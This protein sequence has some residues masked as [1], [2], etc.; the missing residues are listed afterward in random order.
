MKIQAGQVAVI[1]GAG[2]GIGRQLAIQLAQR[3]VNLALVDIN[4]SALEATKESLSSYSISITLHALNIGDC[5]AMETLAGDVIAEHGG[6]NILIN[7][8]GI[9]IQKSFETHSIADWQR[10]MDVNWWGVIYACKFF[11]P[12]LKVAG[13]SNTAHIVNL[14]SMAGFLG[15]PNQASYCSTK[16]A[17]RMLS[18]SLW[19]ELYDDNIGVTSVHPGCVKTD[20]IRATLAESDNVEIAERHYQMAQRIGVSADYAAERMIRAIEKNSLRIRI[21]KDAVVLD[22]LKR[23]LPKGI[24][25]PMIK[26]FRDSAA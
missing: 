2:G 7:N 4:Q 8:A 14:S 25:K 1:T 22:L 23:L 18:E 6:V 11:L 10:V 3:G 24:L 13:R 9:T 15:L 26:V 20:L 19:S 16:S 17:V 5:E 12:A 21:G